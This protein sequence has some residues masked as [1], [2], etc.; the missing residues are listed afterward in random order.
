MKQCNICWNLPYAVV[1]YTDQFVS[2]RYL[3][4]TGNDYTAFSLPLDRP[5]SE[6]LWAIGITT[7]TI[8]EKKGVVVSQKEFT[9]VVA[10]QTIS[11][12]N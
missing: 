10:S 6:K 3:I 4:H 11:E 8:T 7:S 5:Y 12:C 9:V 2:S 1:F